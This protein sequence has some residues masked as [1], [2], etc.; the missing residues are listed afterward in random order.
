M[1]NQSPNSPSRKRNR[2][3][4]ASIQMTFAES[5]ND[6]LDKIQRA[7]T[8]AAR[9]RADTEQWFPASRLSELRVARAGSVN[10]A[11]SYYAD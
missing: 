5:L 11:Y 6:N 8:K 10:V 3:R 1:M 9:R 4:V 7:A 2:L